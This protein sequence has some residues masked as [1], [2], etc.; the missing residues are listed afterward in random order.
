MKTV[1]TTAEMRVK[2]TFAAT[3]QESIRESSCL[4]S[5]LAEILAVA[6]SRKP[7]SKN[8]RKK[9]AVYWA[10]P[11]SPTSS[12]PSTR[13]LYPWVS[14]PR[15]MLENCNIYSITVFSSRLWRWR[16]RHFSLRFNAFT[17]SLI[18]SLPLQLEDQVQKRY[19]APLQKL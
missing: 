8:M 5:R 13:I 12:T 17:P 10:A 18:G 16:D 6:E 14:I 19:H 2:M 1:S 4:S 9:L 3:T 11:K 7:K 15:A